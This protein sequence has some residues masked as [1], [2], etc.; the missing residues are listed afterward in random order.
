M[1]NV[2]DS[3]YQFN[4]PFSLSKRIVAYI[5]DSLL[6]ILAV[7][8]CFQL[9]DVLY[10]NFNSSLKEINSQMT[11][12]QNDIIGCLA[13][14]G[15]M[16]YDEQAGAAVEDELQGQNFIYSLV[17]STLRDDVS[18]EAAY[19]GEYIFSD[20]GKT[21]RFFIYYYAQFKLVHSDG[22]IGYDKSKAGRE[23]AENLFLTACNN[24]ENGYFGQSFPLLDK[25]VAVA[26]DRLIVNRE[27]SCEIDGVTYYGRDIFI[28]L[29]N[30]FSSVLESARAEFT[31]SYRP[32][33]ELNDTFSSLREQLVKIKTGELC[34]AYFAAAFICFMIVPAIF[35]GNSVALLLLRGRCIGRSGLKMRWYN[36]VL[37]WMCRSLFYFSN[38]MFV[39]LLTYG[40]YASFFLTCSIAGGLKL[41]M[42]CLIPVIVMLISFVIFASDK[43]ERRTLTDRLSL[44]V[45][46]EKE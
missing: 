24:S 33:A 27:N 45:V 19:K 6:L 36:Y 14:S 37:R 10:V 20:M 34:I 4:S 1:A 30:A 25:N 16:Q 22:F 42:L 5:I 13:D 32:F 38:I 8:L 35:R 46:K 7:I 43:L 2:H 21:D 44:T 11:S 18:D 40:R 15:L 3:E 12:E 28:E 29:Y 23:Y 9:V 31:Q 17:L 26:L 39:L 41:Y